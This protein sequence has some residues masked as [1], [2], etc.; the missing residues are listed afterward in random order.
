ML[1]GMQSLK[2]FSHLIRAFGPKLTT[3]KVETVM[4]TVPLD[5][6]GL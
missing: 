4:M 6:I 3:L 2:E 1:G 5:V